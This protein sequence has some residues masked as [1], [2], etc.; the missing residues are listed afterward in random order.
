MKKILIVV[1]AQNDFVTGI[2][3][4]LDA[5][6]VL[7][8]IVK[9]VKE[10]QLNND[11]VWYIQDIHYSGDY[12]SKND[13]NDLPVR[14]IEYCISDTNGAEICDELKELGA[15]TNLTFKKETFG[16]KE[17]MSFIEQF[18]D[19]DDIQFE[20]VGFYTD[21]S[22]ISNIVLIKTICPNI[23]VVVDESCCIGTTRLKHTDALEVL[24]SLD[25]EILNS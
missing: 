7:S 19:K 23:H 18:S 1:N 4:S 3:G 11:E 8:N 20:L 2:L 17:L 14:P 16:A 15:I 10:Y 12:S 24:K 13:N 25:I 21:T 22:I 9:K 6:T 5:E